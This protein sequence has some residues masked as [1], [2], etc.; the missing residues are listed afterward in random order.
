[1]CCQMVCQA[2]QSLST[3]IPRLRQR[4]LVCITRAY[5]LKQRGL[6]EVGEPLTRL[7]LAGRVEKNKNTKNIQRQGF[8]SRHRTNY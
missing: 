3:A 6:Q 1:M 5:A 8:A 4:R 2:L 7:P